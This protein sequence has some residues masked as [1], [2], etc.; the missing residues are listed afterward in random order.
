M[1][2]AAKK[3]I[4]LMTDPAQALFGMV[5]TQARVCVWLHD[6][7]ITYEGYLLGIDEHM[8]VVLGEAFEVHKGKRHEVGSV[9]LKGDAISLVCAAS[10]ELKQEDIK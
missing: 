5:Q 3:P 7:D 2:T 4:K 6:S 9:L 1:A 10:K 8:N